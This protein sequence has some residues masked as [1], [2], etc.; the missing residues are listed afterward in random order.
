MLPEEAVGREGAALGGGEAQVGDVRA[1]AKRVE[2]SERAS[3]GREPRIPSGAAHLLTRAFP[4]SPLLSLA[5]TS[6][7]ARTASRKPCSTRSRSTPSRSGGRWRSTWRRS[8]GSR[9]CTRTGKGY[10]RHTQPHTAQNAPFVRVHAQFVS[11]R[12]PA[13]PLF[14]LCV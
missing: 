3:T 6:T 9:C 14:T 12:S 7:L 4:P 5:G 1:R 13:T 11:S 2:T 10:K 8:R